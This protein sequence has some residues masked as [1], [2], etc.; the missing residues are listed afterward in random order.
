M[1]DQKDFTKKHDLKECL[2][3]KGFSFIARNVMQKQIRI[4]NKKLSSVDVFLPI[5]EFVK[6]R[7]L[8]NL[9]ISKEKMHVL[10][11]TVS[12]KHI[13][14]LSK[15]EARKILL[16]EINKMKHSPSKEIKEIKKSTW[17]KIVVY[18][19]TLSEE[20]GVLLIPEIAKL[21]PDYLFVIVG[22]GILE[23]KLKGKN[24]E[25]LGQK[26]SATL[27]DIYKAADV[28]IVPSLWNE[29]F[30]R[31]VVEATLNECALVT[32]N[33]GALP[34]V[35]SWV[36]NGSVIEPTAKNF[37]K[38]IKTA[39]YTKPIKLPDHAKEYLIA[40]SK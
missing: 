21:L 31:V 1:K 8:E 18:A 9:S 32:S 25:K 38:A 23:N 11:N 4:L 26:D 15:N 24:I 12:E 37:V 33:K 40:I 22:S 34:E 3:G 20:K 16:S 36:K 6:R 7:Y 10:Y 19:G 5:S 14:L 29:P 13:S 27:R 35:V 2:P 39:K 17:K 30:G 28:V